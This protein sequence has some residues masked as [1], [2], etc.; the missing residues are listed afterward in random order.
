MFT[1]KTAWLKITPAGSSYVYGKNRINRQ[2][3]G[4][5]AL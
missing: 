1:G 5:V 3:K 2:I 4:P